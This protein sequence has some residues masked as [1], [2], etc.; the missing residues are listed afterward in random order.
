MTHL[1]SSQWC[2][3]EET[4]ELLG[5]GS[6]APLPALNLFFQRIGRRGPKMDAMRE[7]LVEKRSSGTLVFVTHQ[8][9]ISALTN[10]YTTSGDM[11]IA[12]FQNNGRLD[13]VGSIKAD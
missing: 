6:V 3:C 12:R 2:R 7:W 13:I 4:A 8:F 10:H 9:N 11:I 5:L 1:F